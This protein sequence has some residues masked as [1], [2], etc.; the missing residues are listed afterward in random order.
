MTKVRELTI[1]QAEAH[2][3][4]QSELAS[5][6]YEFVYGVPLESTDEQYDNY[7]SDA[8]DILSTHP[9]LLPLNLREDKH[10]PENDTHD[11]EAPTDTYDPLH[12][13]IAH[14][15][16]SE[17]TTEHSVLT[18]AVPVGTQLVE[19]EFPV[20]ARVREASMVGTSIVLVIQPDGTTYSD[21]SLTFTLLLS[22]SVKITA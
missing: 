14:L 12:G 21:E 5:R 1:E 18:I 4:R 10:D 9:H 17:I 2:L 8:Y 7:M 22:C 19:I 13:N 20:A 6:F 3:A 15:F 16:A 11:E